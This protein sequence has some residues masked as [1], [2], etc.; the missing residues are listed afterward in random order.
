MG[1][2]IPVLQVCGLP[3]LPQV[4][5]S[6][7]SL[8][9]QSNGGGSNTDPGINALDLFSD[10]AAPGGHSG[11]GDALGGNLGNAYD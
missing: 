5:A 1:L 6:L 3:L 4:P 10:N 11:S 2:L 8:L 7:I 9:G